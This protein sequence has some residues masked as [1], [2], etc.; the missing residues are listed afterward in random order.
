MCSESSCKSVD[1]YTTKYYLNKS[2]YDKINNPLIQCTSSECTT[3][4][5]LVGYYIN[6]DNKL[7]QCTS[8]S[9]CTIKDGEVGS[10]Y[11]DEGSRSTI[12][13]VHLKIIYC[14]STTSCSNETINYGYVINGADKTKVIE[15]SGTSYIS[16]DASESNKTKYYLNVS[17]Y[18]KTTNPLIK[19]DN[20]DECVTIIALAGY[21]INAAP[22]NLNSLKK[23]VFLCN[24]NINGNS[25]CIEVETVSPDSIYINNDDGKLIQCF[26][27]S[28]SGDNK[29][30]CFPLTDSSILGT[31]DIPTYFVN[32]GSDSKSNR[33]I[34]CIYSTDPVNNSCSLIGI[35][36][37]NVYLNGN[38]KN[39][40]NIYGED[41]PLIICKEDGCISASKYYIFL[42]IKP[43][44]QFIFD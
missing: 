2:E 13:E 26:N 32:A 39:E 9:S 34:K 21:Y 28:S 25:E 23:A 3:M 12:E 41:K 20:G 11:L 36:K 24:I 40:N 7:I 35:E 37:Y 38:V 1:P 30:G 43:I 18:D 44:I 22:D 10:Y 27:Y 15:C 42:K 19:C 16:I 8:S 6:N 14:E 4:T 33:I 5:A 29:K 17:A 31:E